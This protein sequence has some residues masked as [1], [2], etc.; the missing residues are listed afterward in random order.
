MK[1]YCL[2]IKDI[3]LTLMLML[4]PAIAMAQLKAKGSNSAFKPAPKHLVKSLNHAPCKKALK[5][6]MPATKAAKGDLPTIYG[7]V[8]ND[9][10]DYYIGSF[11]PKAD[12]EVE[13]VFESED[14]DASGGAVYAQGNL[15]VNWMYEE[16]YEVST[17][18]Y[19]FDTKTWDLI[20]TREDLYQSSSASCLAY[21]ETTD[22][23]Y[24]CYYD[25]SGTDY[26]GFGYTT[27]SNP[28]PEYITFYEEDDTPLV[29]AIGSDGVIYAIDVNGKFLT[30][31]KETGKQTV[32]GHTDVKPQ[33][34]QDAVIDPST[35]RF[36]WAAF[37]DDERGALYEVNTA[38]GEATLIAYFPND[39][40]FV[41]LYIPDAGASDD[42]P[43]DVTDLTFN[44][45]GASL[46]GTISYTIP[47]TTISGETLS[48]NLKAYLVIDGNTYQKEA[49][50]GTFCTFNV[51]VENGG[52]HIAMAYTEGDGG[53]SNK[54][55]FS[56]W[57]GYDY[58]SGVKNLL[59]T[60]DG[61]KAIITWDAPTTGT[62]DGY[63]NPDELT[64]IIC[65]TG[66]WKEGY[67][68]TSFT[69]D[70]GDKTGNISYFVRAVQHELPGEVVYTDEVY[71]G[72]E[73]GAWDVPST[74]SFSGDYESCTIID[75]NNDGSGW[76]R[77][78]NDYLTCNSPRS[79][80]AD[81][82]VITPKFK[83]QAG[84]MYKITYSAAAQMGPIYPEVMEVKMGMQN[85]VAGMT[86]LIATEQYDDIFQNT[87]FS[88]REQYLTVEADGDYC[89]GFHAISTGGNKLYLQSFSIEA[90]ANV[91][92]PAAVTNLQL[93]AGAEG[94]LEAIISFT[95]PTV[96]L[97]G[98][99][100]T[101]IGRIDILREDSVVHSF[102]S[103]V[104]G[105]D[106][107]YTDN[108]AQQGYN[109]YKVTTY[110]AEGDKGLE[111]EG[112]VYCG[113]EIPDL[114]GNVVL[115]LDNDVVTLTWEAPT[116]GINGGYVNPSEV[117]YT[118][119]DTSYGDVVADDI[120]GTSFSAKVTI[121]E[122][123]Q[124]GFN[125]AIGVRNVA[126][127]NEDV[128]VSNAVVVGNPYELPIQESF[129]RGMPAYSWFLV[130]DMLDDDGWEMLEHE[131]ENTGYARFYGTSMW[132]G[133]EQSM[134]LGKLSLKGAENP[135]LRFNVSC[136]DVVGDKLLVRISNS[137]YGPYETL[138]EITFN[139]KTYDSWVPVEIPLHQYVNRDYVHISFHGIPEAEDCNIFVDEIEVRNVYAHDAALMAFA[140]SDRLVEVGKTTAKVSVT[141]Q[142][143]G[144]ENLAQ[145]DYTL[146]V[147]AGER[148]VA[149]K[150][151]VA[152]KP[153]EKWNTSCDYVPQTVD[154]DNVV[155][156]AE[157][158]YAGDEDL[159]NNTSAS[160]MVKVVKPELPA[161]TDLVATDEAGGTRL[162]WSQP[163]LSGAPVQTVTDSFE[164]Y[165]LFDI[166]RAGD[167]TFYDEDGLPTY[168]DYYFT[169][170]NEPMAFIVMNPGQVKRLYGKT[171]ADTWPAHSGEQYMAAF[172]SVG[173]DN[174]DWMVSPQL[175]G[176]AQ[177]VS[178]FARSG[179][180]DA[181]H[182]MVEL[183]YST[184]DNTIESMTKTGEEVYKIA[185]GEWTEYSV[186]LPEGAK[187][188][189]IRCISHSR[190][191]L[192][193]DDVTYESA[194][195]PLK[196]V[197]AGYNVYC[198]DELLTAAPI[199]ETNYL[200]SGIDADAVYYVT[201]VYDLGESPASNCVSV[202]ATGIG[203]PN[204]DELRDAV[205]YDLKGCRVATPEHN[206][207]YIVNGRKRIVK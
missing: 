8:L 53:Q 199:T 59:L 38:T 164:E 49:Q 134:I 165:L 169:G 67:T 173:G 108:T 68:S 143:R 71:F 25:D 149:Q 57:L 201:V 206:N 172:R 13:K 86:R 23:I 79:G 146:V 178:F 65:R 112:S 66:M 130:G 78:W 84:Q 76:S 96:D 93:M 160:Y 73:A 128:I 139:D 61:T 153:Y 198:N 197:F 174:D 104:P 168:T 138:K 16:W 196:A 203:Q 12:L 64:Y 181:G 185:Y 189:A 176:N 27:T 100:L 80:A 35:G 52:E 113:V 3:A 91:S 144:S 69:E 123:R 63:V 183:Y 161:V 99:E 106:Y 114:P 188:F 107:T 45:E 192:M 44:F 171:L 200:V 89:F 155:L 145:G 182:E 37:T 190:N 47:A 205:I 142:N 118:I 34:M 33:Y 121:Y 101:A 17:T 14:L 148:I 141:V 28:E 7:I 15:Y 140:V 191:A 156:H 32:I 77:G 50:A 19:V 147:Y 41:G 6:M 162:L 187:Y 170:R 194:A 81:D 115:T 129:D 60:R 70:L 72:P 111:A 85:T 18:Q 36:Y 40:E 39:E 122:N 95:A 87:G 30:I 136:G 24:G 120:T 116:K 180:E 177:T 98:A 46:T 102:D 42:A 175:S 88:V 167:W 62:H 83:L 117:I 157:V 133:E 48:G 154:D 58:P 103:P 151:G 186:E 166:N 75:A 152:L 51:T 163:D 126:G 9:D 179:S 135:I 119:Y 74:I 5:S 158:E 1:H 56:K 94:A 21:D 110:S 29:M 55:K 131:G 31:D 109:N 20:E 150:E 193:I 11:Q 204:A 97:A 132:G 202:V 137:I 92:A 207:V 54:V 184:A 4:L 82:W 10:W 125:L 105:A 2:N 127:T 26:M 159:Q 195:R 90:S 124:Y 43:A 22:R